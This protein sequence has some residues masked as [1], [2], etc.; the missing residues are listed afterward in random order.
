VIDGGALLGLRHI[1]ERGSYRAAIKKQACYAASNVMA[2]TH[3]QVQ[4]ALDAGLAAPLV[5]LLRHADLGVRKEA[6]W[7]VTNA[8]HDGTAEQIRAF[9]RLGCIPPLCALLDAPDEDAAEAAL[10]GLSSIL[11]AGDELARAG[12][13][14][15][16]GGGNPY[17][18]EAEE[19]GAFD[20]LEA[21]AETGDELLCF[22]ARALLERCVRAFG[23]GGAAVSVQ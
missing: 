14:G 4:A 18:R 21:L 2:G 9:V 5:H 22:R 19:A 11:S 15:D 13:G 7:A 1:M 16:S 3:E 20:K 23:D 6:A 10:D 8:A 17:L 12:G